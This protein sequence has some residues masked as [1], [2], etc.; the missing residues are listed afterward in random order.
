MVK[1]KFVAYPILLTPIFK[2]KVWGGRN[3]ETLFDKNL[4][5]GK[6]IG[7]SWE[8]SDRPGDSCKIRNGVYRGKDI[9]FLF[10]NYN[11]ELLSNTKF[12]RFPLLIKF[13]DSQADLSVQVHPDDAYANKNEKGEWGKTECWYVIDAKKNARIV[14]GL[15]EVKNKSELKK[16]VQEGK[17]RNHLNYVSVRK[18]DFISMPA[19][20]VH[21]LLKDVVVAEIQQSSDLTYRLY[22]WDRKIID[23]SRPLHINQAI[24]VTN[25][26]RK[27]PKTVNSKSEDC[28]KLI[29]C[30]Y[31]TVE[32]LFLK[33]E[34]IFKGNSKFQIYTIIS[35]EGK[36]LYDCVASVHLNDELAKQD[37]KANQKTV[38]VKKGYNVIIPASLKNFRIV[39]QPK[40]EMLF[41]TL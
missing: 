26:K 28:I 16:I 31:F 7:E 23:G 41:T 40:I 32:K 17:L 37:R 15:K 18:G 27:L 1:T 39:P 21:A 4:P 36:I 2:E 38:F 11:K 3:L 35:G 10:K 19:G 13:I 14:Y 24:D 25:L 12:D 8:V 34:L 30:K 20:T 29:D 22:D 33:D 9:H 5:K 6:L